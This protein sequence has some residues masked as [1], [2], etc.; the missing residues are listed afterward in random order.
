MSRVHDARHLAFIRQLPC[1]TCRNPHETEACHIR[2]SDARYGKVNPG[3]GKKPDD[4]YTLPMCG[5]CHRRQHAGNE[6]N[7]WL[8][9]Q[10]DP[11]GTAL[12]LYN[13]SG[14]IELAMKILQK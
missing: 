13:V 8:L 1:I 11:I 14:N 6:R 9:H 5:R 12:E 7:F 10:I 4:K 2:Y 3:I